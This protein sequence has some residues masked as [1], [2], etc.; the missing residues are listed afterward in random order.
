ME[1][2]QTRLAALMY[3]RA[4]GSRPRTGLANDIGDRKCHRARP[5]KIAGGNGS[6]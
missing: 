1:A 5:L 4:A 2:L 6:R 3:G